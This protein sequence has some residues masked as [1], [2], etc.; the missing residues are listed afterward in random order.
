VNDR[1]AAG[2]IRAESLIVLCCEHEGRGFR[3][4]I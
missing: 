3:G 4:W 1:K 2:L